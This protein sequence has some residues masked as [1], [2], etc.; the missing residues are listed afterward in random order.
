MPYLPDGRQALLLKAALLDG[1]VALASWQAWRQ[2]VALEDIDFASA[3]LIPLLL[4]NLQR[5]GVRHPELHRYQNVARHTWLENQLLAKHA[6]AV[7]RM[8]SNASIAAMP[9][10]GLA[11]A[12]LYYG[13][14]RLRAM[15]DVDLLVPV[16]VARKAACLLRDYGWQSKCFN[17]MGRSDYFS[18][19]HACLFTNAGNVQL[20]LHW[21]VCFDGCRTVADDDFWRHAS[22]M[23]LNGLETRSLCDTDQLFHTLVHGGRANP[24]APIRWVA[25]S[26]MI[27]RK[28]AIDWERLLSHA[29]SFGVVLRLRRMLGYLRDDMGLAVPEAVAARLMALAVTSLERMESRIELLAEPNTAK[30]LLRRYVHYRR[31]WVPEGRIG[32]LRYL[33]AVHGL[34]S[35]AHTLLWGIARI[36][37]GRSR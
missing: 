36:A 33:Q 10:K 25:D 4:A 22:P 27:M 18:T 16:A 26:T 35:T 20:D 37:A 34:R 8:F 29:Q 3:R 32:F 2:S 21:H 15:S 9:L 24:V 12:P 23:S 30:S 19:I 13:N 17:L 7:M 14:L 11:V 6:M 28:A 31:T 1:E 5:L